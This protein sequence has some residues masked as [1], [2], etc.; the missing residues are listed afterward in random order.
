M[1]ALVGYV[2]KIRLDSVVNVLQTL[3]V[4][5]DSGRRWDAGESAFLVRELEH[6]ISTVYETVYQEYRARRFI[7]VDNSVPSGASSYV[8]KV[9]DH[10]GMAKILHSYADDLPLVGRLAKEFPAPIRGIGNGF[11]WSIQDI[12]AALFARRNL[13]NELLLVARR[14]A[15]ARVD[16]IAAFGDAAFGLAGFLNHPNVTL[17][18]PVTGNWA[19]ATPLQILQDMNTLA[20]AVSTLSKRTYTADTMLLDETSWDIVTQTPMSV[21]NTKTIIKTFLENSTNVR[22][23]DVWPS[24]NLADAAGTGPRAVAYARTPEVASLVIP[25]EF[26][27]FPPQ[28][29]NLSFFVPCHLRC[30]GISMKY[31]IGVAYMDGL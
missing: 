9:W 27:T 5:H 6:V 23:I 22:N 28:A 11:A 29:K 18:P 14:T 31:P 3:D 19:T 8:Y 7:P 21:D 16:A 25:Q 12:R 15:E 2:P 26:E 20:T 13:N 17:T 10:F 24:L 1:N 30:G 4:R